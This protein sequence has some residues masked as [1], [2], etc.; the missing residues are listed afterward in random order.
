MSLL[1]IKSKNYCKYDCLSLG[2]VI[3]RLDPG[4]GRVRTSRQFQAWEGGGVFNLSRGLRRCFG[5]QTAIITAFADNE[6]GHL[7]E[8]F[9]F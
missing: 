2:E 3:L 1:N 7:I 9:I 4:E 8:D 6:I 5:L